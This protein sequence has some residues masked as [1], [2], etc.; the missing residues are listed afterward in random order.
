MFESFKENRTIVLKPV[1]VFALPYKFTLGRAVVYQN[2]LHILGGTNYSDNESL[3]HY[4]WDGENWVNESTLPYNFYGG[5]CVVFN[6]EIHIM[7]SNNDSY[8]TSHYA[9]NGSSWSSVSTL[10]ANLYYGRGVIYNDIIHVLGFGTNA[11]RNWGHYSFNGTNWTYVSDIKI[12]NTTIS[13]QRCDVVIYNSK[14]CVLRD[15]TITGWNGT[16]WGTMLA[17]GNPI[18]EE[19]D[20][21]C[22]TY[23]GSIYVMGGNNSSSSTAK[24]RI[25][26]VTGTT[27][28]APY[29]LL[30]H[31]VTQSDSLIYKDNLYVIGGSWNPKTLLN[32][33]LLNTFI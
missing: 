28:T 18:I 8:R 24:R 32:V 19:D 1:S 5:A 14:I 31:G 26:K 12:D 7:G 10:P 11:S 3:K 21:T 15:S 13:L 2:K 16:S 29:S 33:S 25:T 4:S 23:N 17:S 30:P 22:T 27:R 9:W 20:A 6:G